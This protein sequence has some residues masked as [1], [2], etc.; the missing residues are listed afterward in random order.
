M[1]FYLKL[2]NK[3][4]DKKLEGM[5]LFSDFGKDYFSDYDSSLTL[6]EG[7]DEYYFRT[8][9]EFYVPY[10]GEMERVFARLAAIL[11]D[12]RI[13]YASVE[14]DGTGESDVMLKMEND[15]TIYQ[16]STLWFEDD[17]P[18]IGDD[19]WCE[20]VIRQSEEE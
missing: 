16:C 10:L 12:A 5:V 6:G 15:S 11:P 1:E 17:E 19:E 2:A 20:A 4:D 18:D 3:E 13:C 8:E 14:D 7:K 9:E